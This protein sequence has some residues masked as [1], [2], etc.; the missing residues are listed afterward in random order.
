MQ[1][2]LQ[3]QQLCSS[4]LGTKIPRNLKDSTLPLDSK[5]ACSVLPVMARAG[6]ST[7]RDHVSSC[8]RAWIS[9]LQ[10]FKFRVP[11]NHQYNFMDQNHSCVMS[12]T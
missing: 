12:S 7:V 8:A 4:N 11:V 5:E 6:L 1:S 10:K 3:T 2:R 9:E